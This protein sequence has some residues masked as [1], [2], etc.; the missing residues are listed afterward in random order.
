[1]S[2]L[3]TLFT[4]ALTAGLLGTASVANA[5]LGLSDVQGTK[6][7]ISVKYEKDM[8]SSPM[9]APISMIAEDI[10]VNEDFSAMT[11]GS[12]AQPDTTQFLASEI[13][14]PGI[15]IDPSLTKD[16]QWAGNWAYQAG[17]MVYLKTPTPYNHAYV[18]TPLGDYSGDITITCRVKAVTCWI[19]SGYDE[20]QNPIWN[21][22]T[23]SS[24]G[25]SVLTGGFDK[26]VAAELDGKQSYNDVRLYPD[27]GWAQVT[28]KLTNYSADNDGTI[29]LY[30]TEAVVIDDVKVIANNES[31]IASPKINGITDFQPNQFTISWQP[32]RKA[33]NYYLDLYTKEYVTDE[34]KSFSMDFEDGTIAEGWETN[35]TEF[36][37]TEGV[38]GS[39][40]LVL[41]N[42]QSITFPI[43]GAN[44]DQAKV[45]LKI[46]DPANPPSDEDPYWMYYIE[47][48]VQVEVYDIS[49]GW[50]S[51]G[52][53]Q[54]YKLYEG[55]LTDMAREIKDLNKY[56]G[57]RLTA[58][59]MGDDAYILVDNAELLTDRIME[60]VPVEGE[61]SMNYGDNYTY[62]DSTDDTEFTFTNLD[63]ETEYYY[64]VRSHLVNQFSQRKYI[65]ALGVSA[66]KALLATDIDARGSFTANW[67]AA[68]K[69]TGYTVNLYGINKMSESQADFTIIEEGF[70]KID[71]EVTSATSVD[72]PENLGNS[73]DTALDDATMLPGWTGKNNTMVQGM[74]GCQ[75]SM[76]SPNYI[77]TPI[78]YLANENPV[79]LTLI[80]Y[81]QA[82][83]AL[84]VEINGVQYNI[85]LEAT[86]DTHA[87]MSGKV[88]NLPVS[89]KTL[90][91]KFTS[92]NKLPFL[93]DYFRISQNV[94]KGDV[95][96]SWLQTAETGKDEL[97][98]TFSNLS[99]WE[100]PLFAYDVI[101]QFVYSERE[102]TVSQPSDLILVDL[103]QENSFS[104]ISSHPTDVAGYTASGAE[105]ERFTIDGRRA[106]KGQK[107]LII[108]RQAD[109]SVRKMIVK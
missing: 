32:T 74:L 108:V 87:V 4:L 3:S 102:Q 90:Q 24:F 26:P 43:I 80:A 41:R 12:F 65:H 49:N 86:D 88:E 63:P 78:I 42:G 71:A 85:N 95:V 54:A 59:G 67:E 20:Q 29:R 70:D 5:Q 27:Q 37:E 15:L 73:G 9:K 48:G 81:G 30:T 77:T 104:G 46:T 36:S 47:G 18:S 106:D 99:D 84:G 101:S 58:M 44:Y 11:R 83:D 17:G 79:T 50:E 21:R 89:G 82:G 60:Y 55:H 98:Y 64:G 39:K 35:S 52:H 109:G 92:E 6:M 61:N 28:I 105:A 14:E 91:I 31:F 8:A 19:I 68:P 1:M 93:I 107:G 13:Y 96:R 53:F 33:F 45:W 34:G 25:V 23:G 97:S 22:W 75:S 57:L 66:P 10:L 7:S 76:Y 51:L 40:A 62:Y 100:F 38:D 56:S 2:K 16:G 69:A 103:D 94:N 72:E